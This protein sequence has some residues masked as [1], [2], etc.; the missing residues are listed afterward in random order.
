MKLKNTTEE[1]VRKDGREKMIVKLCRLRDFVLG[2]N[3]EHYPLEGGDNAHEDTVCN[4]YMI[5]LPD[6]QGGKS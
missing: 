5:K 6:Y 1:K 3:N 4:L 2:I